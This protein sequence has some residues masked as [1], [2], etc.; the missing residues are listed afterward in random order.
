MTVNG[1][2]EAEGLLVCFGKFVGTLHPALRYGAY[3]ILV[4]G[5]WLDD[6][7][8]CTFHTEQKSV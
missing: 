8:H 6:V 1:L 4:Q 7:Q 5:F 3:H 2:L